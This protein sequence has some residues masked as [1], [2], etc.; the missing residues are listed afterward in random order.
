MNAITPA[1]FGQLPA[2]RITAADGAQAV[3]TLYGAH[4]VSWKGAD[5]QERIF[6]SAKSALDGS[7]AIRGG[8]PVIFP[9]FNE[10]GSGMRHGFARVSTW[11]L[12]EHGADGDTSFAEFELAPND[13]A[14]ERAAAW[15]H[16]FRL[17]LRVTVGANKLAMALE[18][19]N[20]GADAF[21]F[22]CALHTYHLVD[23]IGAVR[24]DGLQAGPLAIGDTLDEIFYGVKGQ[25]T[26]HAGSRKVELDQD[27]FTDAVVWNPGAANAAA[28]PDL[29]DD[30]YQRF[31]CIEPACI[32]PVTLA[33]GAQWRGHYGV[34]SQMGSGPQDQTPAS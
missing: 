17:R 23:S 19:D 26:L 30:E 22:S 20:R 12:G 4:L 24:I 32:E 27:G 34:S 31:V 1:T 6:C 25:V 13:L 11:A 28:M 33:G 8:V 16:D 9:Q 5:G 10:R 7:R 2:V 14:P 21:A 15:P 3:V 29:E 18:V